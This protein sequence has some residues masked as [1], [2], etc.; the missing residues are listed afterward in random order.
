MGISTSLFNSKSKP[1]VEDD[2]KANLRCNNPFSEIQILNAHEDIIRA[3][4]VINP[5]TSV[6]P[7]RRYSLLRFASAADD[8]NII[9][10]NS[11]TGEQQFV[12]SGHTRPVTCLLAIH[13]QTLVSGSVDKSL[14]VPP[15]RFFS[16][17]HLSSF[18]VLPPENASNVFPTAT[19]AVSRFNSFNSSSLFLFVL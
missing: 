13:Q 17:I 5:T 3:F 16:M 15:L 14:R 6:L 1:S 4:L 12:L 10:W 2:K 18:G 11:Q 9:I 19:V 8:G 7:F